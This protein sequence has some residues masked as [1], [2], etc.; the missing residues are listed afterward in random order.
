MAKSLSA[1]RRELPQLKGRIYFNHGASSVLPT[2]V[3]NASIEGVRF[4]ADYSFRKSTQDRWREVQH[5]TRRLAAELIGASAENIAFVAST[6]TALSLISLAIPWKRGDNVITCGVENPATVVPWQN[7]RHLGVEV[8][9]LPADK[10]DLIDLNALPGA[11]DKRTRLVALSLVEYSTGQRLNLRKVAD[12]CRPRGVLVSADAV[13]AVGAVPVDVKSLGVHFLSAG[14]QKWLMG[15]RGIAVLYADDAALD[16]V[17]SPIVTESNVLDIGAEEEQPT[18]GIPRLRI[19]EGALKFEAVP[20]NNFAGVCGLRQAL[21]NIRD[22]GK[23]FLFERLHDITAELVERLNGLDGRVVSPRG[24]DEWSGIVSFAP[25]GVPARDIVRTLREN[26]VYIAVR[27]GRLRICPHYY[28][29]P[30]EVRRFVSILK[31][32]MLWARKR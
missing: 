29:T 14:A 12:L 17:R 6:S 25:D 7:L 24:K 8:R 11:I 4:G 10:D 32:A 22:I 18:R 23:A 1:F 2:S 16:A 19:H 26:G 27:K 28:N 3:L 20:Y 31:D 21:R 15:P 30:A 13:Q 5:E 9:Y